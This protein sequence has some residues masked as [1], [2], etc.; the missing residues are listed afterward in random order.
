MERAKQAAE[1]NRI[2]NRPG[3]AFLAGMSA[4]ILTGLGWF[5]GNTGP[6]GPSI[7]LSTLVASLYGGAIGAAVWAFGR[8]FHWKYGAWSALC[9]LAST[10]ISEAM[11]GTFYLALEDGV[12]PAVYL[13]SGSLAVYFDGWRFLLGPF[14]F[15]FYLIAV[16][17]AFWFG[18][19]SYPG[20]SRFAQFF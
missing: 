4:A 16:V 19:R 10:V 2:G 9:S 5:F 7:I 6:A 17:S 13:A 18:W 14:Q 11:I 12:Q 20:D 1:L 15:I 3:R 8:G